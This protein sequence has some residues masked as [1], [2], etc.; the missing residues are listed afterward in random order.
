MLALLAHCFDSLDTHRVEAEIEPAN[1]RSA[2]LAER[3]GFDARACSGIV[4]TWPVNRDHL[5]VFLVPSGMEETMTN[6]VACL[7]V[8]GNEVLSGR[9]Q[10]ANIRFLAVGLGAIGIPC[11]RCGSFPTYPK[12]SSP[13]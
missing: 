7:L 2:R 4:S 8:I 3:L 12:P 13:R 5:D 9:T 1:A 6:P 10:D 11:A